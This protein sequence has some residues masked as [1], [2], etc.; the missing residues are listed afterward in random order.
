MKAEQH[1]GQGLTYLNV[2]PD[3]YEPGL[4]YPLVVMLHGFGANMKDLAGLAPSIEREGYVYA[5]PNAPIPFDIG[6]GVSGYGWH[7]PRSEATAEDFQQAE[8]LLDGFFDEVFQQLKATPGQIALLGFSQ[9][10]GMTYRCGLGRPETFAGLVALS[11]SLPDPEVLRPRLPSQRNQPIFIA[12][13][14][15]DPMVGMDTARDTRAFLEAE[16]YQPDYHEY[17]M[18]HEIPPMVL[19]DMVP[20]LA[21]VL[22]PLRK[23]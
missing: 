6:M 10:G 1:Q 13:G 21:E 12:H 22:P 16:G 7:P 18:G 20:W 17:N 23:D 19:N 9:G 15:S 2:Y 5:C 14:S 3:D 8:G 4:S 11:A